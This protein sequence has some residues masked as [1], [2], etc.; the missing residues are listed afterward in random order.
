MEST[1]LFPK[2]E[3]GQQFRKKLI[4]SGYAKQ[5]DLSPSQKDEIQGIIYGLEDNAH[6][7]WFYD[8]VGT[9]LTTGITLTCPGERFESIKSKLEE[10]TKTKLEFEQNVKR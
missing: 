1:Y 10:L 7:H 8:H 3:E 5:K 4:S 6:L 2:R 9:Y